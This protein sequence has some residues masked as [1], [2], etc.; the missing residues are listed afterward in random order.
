M[1]SVPL[2]N[3]NLFVP[4]LGDYTRESSFEKGSLYF[5]LVNHYP[6]TIDTSL[7]GRSFFAGFNNM[8]FEGTSPRFVIAHILGIAS[9]AAPKVAKPFLN[10]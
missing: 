4:G 5:G 6:F 2:G 9:P 1:E 8:D 10:Y 3:H 7:F